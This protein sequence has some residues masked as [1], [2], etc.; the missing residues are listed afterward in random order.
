MAENDAEVRF[1]GDVGELVT[2]MHE[3]KDSVAEAL[4]S[5]HS[6]IEGLLSKFETLAVVIAG[7]AMFREMVDGF[8]QAGDEANRLVHSI[9]LNSAEI[10]GLDN[11]LKENGATLGAYESAFTR[12]NRAIRQHQ[13]QIQSLG[14]DL[15]G[16]NAGQITSRELF[17]QALAATEKYSD[18][19]AR[20]QVQM[21]LFGARGGDMSKVIRAI[22]EDQ[23][24]LAEEDAALG[25]VWTT[26]DQ[27]AMEAY[28]RMKVGASD[29]FEAIEKIITT[30]VMPTL[31]LLAGW[32]AEEG[33]NS[34][35]KFREAM[36]VLS[37]VFASA[38]NAIL[39]VYNSLVVPL[40][41]ALAQLF[42]YVFGASTTDKLGA[43]GHAFKLMGEAIVMTSTVIQVAVEYISTVFDQLTTTVTTV[44]NTITAFFGG[45]GDAISA[46][47]SAKT[48]GE[49][50]TAAVTIMKKATTDAT[51]AWD[52]GATAVENRARL[53]TARI[54]DIFTDEAAS[55]KAIREADGKKA[56]SDILK[57]NKGLDAPDFNNKQTDET[58]AAKLAKAKGQAEIALQ[59][60]FA[61]EEQ[62]LLDAK[63]KNNLIDEA[64]YWRA[65]E[66]LQRQTMNLELAE[67]AKEDAAIDK[68][69]SKLQKKP[70]ETDTQFENK[71]N[72]LLAQQEGVHGRINVLLAQRDDLSHSIA[73][74]LDDALRK[75]QE[76][77]A[78]LESKTAQERGHNRVD[79]EKAESDQL[80]ALGVITKEQ[81]LANE[82]KFEDEIYAIDKRAADDK[83][84][85]AQAKNDTV[86]MATAQQEQEQLKAKHE[87]AMRKLSNQTVLEEKKGLIAVTQAMGSSFANALTS[88]L[89]KTQTFKQAMSGLF[90]S[91][92]DSFISE[93][94]AKPLAEFAMGLLKQSALYKTLAGVK[95]A[96]DTTSVA[97][98]LATQKA[99][100]I[101]GVMSN[102]AIAA[103]AA[104]ASVA[105]IPLTGWEMAPGV[106]T[107]TYGKAMAFMPSASGGYDIPA[108]VNPVTQLH[109]QEMVLPA[110]LANP[111]RDALT[112]GNMGGG[113]QFHIHAVDT[114]GMERLLRDNGHILAREMRRQA[115]NFSPTKA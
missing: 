66:A 28:R 48:V 13:A 45:V 34:S 72:A 82:R 94:V 68:Q 108:G 29:A 37:A 97:T 61:K 106:G 91:I 16:F 76:Q 4:E 99:L 8:I 86:A 114:A 51:S 43:F 92:F 6:G 26:A 75:T 47:L 7:G 64:E 10:A 36:Q 17:E 111:L 67:L 58:G 103:T 14:V 39:A 56:E 83:L 40:R 21:E 78:T 46:F 71:T 89:N 74:S 52:A 53:H 84:A 81:Q 9:G 32:F 88:M 113:D 95:A 93:M 23:T 87:L 20:T 3:A 15:Q 33:L 77:L 24:S 60:E 11:A 57:P 79:Q 102:A 90:K 25:I 69:I 109:Q 54:K 98:Q 107:S 35:I 70:K 100:G 12:F 5:M 30:T 38:W 59:K 1:G 2:A 112:G 62:A 27:Q 31:T 105:A 80:L 63:H 101:A 18:G 85:L 22:H 65:K 115:R 41:D 96:T 110:H 19:M 44:I 50:A 55:L 73:R 104:M 49:G 42:D